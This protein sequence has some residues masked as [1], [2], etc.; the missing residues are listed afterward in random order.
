MTTE[1]HRES[2]CRRISPRRRPVWIPLI[3]GV[4]ACVVVNA[5][6]NPRPSRWS[7]R[8]THLL[9]FGIVACLFGNTRSVNA[10]GQS[11]ERKSPTHG[12][13][14]VTD[15]RWAGTRHGGYYPIRMRLTNTAETVQIG[16]KFVPDNAGE[17]PFVEKPPFELA[18]NAT[19]DVTLLIPLL[20][21]GSSGRIEVRLDGDRVELLETRI[22]LPEVPYEMPQPS[23]LVI[24]RN[25]IGG[26][27]FTKF[28]AAVN[29]SS[30]YATQDDYASIPPVLLP[31]NWLAYSGLDYLAISL[32]ELSTLGSEE[33]SAIL[34]WVRTGGQLIVF[35][36]GS[37]PAAS[38]ELAKR[39]ELPA[40]TADEWQ[41][42]MPGHWRG[43]VVLDE[44]GGYGGHPAEEVDVRRDNISGW[45]VT[46]D[47]FVHRPMLLGHVF[48]FSDNPFT[49]G[50]PADWAWMASVREPHHWTWPNRRGVSPRRE[51]TNFLEFLI[52]GVSSV[53]VYA[54]LILMTLFTIIIGPLNYF[55]FRHRRQIYMLLLTIPGLAFATSL[56]LFAYSLVS[57]GFDVESR[58][59]SLIMV[60]QRTNQSVI[61]S[62]VA[63]FAGMVPS[64]GLHFSPETEIASVWPS[65]DSMNAGRV[66]WSGEQ[67]FTDGF[68]RAHTRTQF[69]TLTPLPQRGRLVIEP[70]TDGRLRVD[71][72]F[73]WEIEQLIVSDEAGKVFLSSDLEPGGS[74]WAA[75][76]EQTQ[77][78]DFVNRLKEE[79]LEIPEGAVVS[80]GRRDWQYGRYQHYNESTINS[81]TSQ[82]EMLFRNFQTLADANNV[83]PPNTYLAILADNPD[84]D[85]METITGLADTTVQSGYYLVYGRY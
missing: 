74:G 5:R 40:D 51:T 77:L 43:V 69:H 67:V 9:V 18:A 21:Y 84:A 23:L 7:W 34:Q 14:I 65:E 15:S 55:F 35:D 22:N 59:R 81:Q 24:S 58:V 32:Q 50:T 29:T 73:E 64:G 60:D 41:R 30:Y 66:V 79:P 63:L 47:T 39:L 38:Q 44:A 78:R 36:S 54:F 70:N 71:N 57:H 12:I 80:T 16:L 17:L 49:S 68:F 53:P 19:E 11:T 26:E 48:A 83:L 13:R 31:K 1:F 56:T 82:V 75:V 37:D 62:R 28:V 76:P 42:P 10:A 6:R 20:G 52:P 8:A 46:E 4:V 85:T 45:D 72:G 61:A 27:S 2:A 25:N 3:W 33:R